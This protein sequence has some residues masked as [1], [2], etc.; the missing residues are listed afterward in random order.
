VRPGRHTH[1]LFSLL[2][3]LFFARLSPSHAT[4]QPQLFYHYIH[5]YLRSHQINT[6]TFHPRH[7]T[8]FGNS[9]YCLH[10]RHSPPSPG[11]LTKHTPPELQLPRIFGF[12]TR[13]FLPRSASCLS[14]IVFAWLAQTNMPACRHLFKT[15]LTASDKFGLGFFFFCRGKETVQPDPCR[16]SWC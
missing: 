9:T 16:R 7:F 12:G 10:S 6:L 14:T 4:S 5:I 2:T 15:N 8:S 13:P 1:I 11:T 3:V